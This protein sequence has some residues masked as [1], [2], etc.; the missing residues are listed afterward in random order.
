MVSAPKKLSAGH[1]R[2]LG[3]TPEGHGTNFAI[4]GR[5][6][7]SME[8][9]L[10]H[11]EKD[12]QPD[13]ITLSEE[14]YRSG[15]YWHVHVA[16]VTAGQLYAWRVKETFSNAPGTHFDPEKVLLDPYG[17][18]IVLSGNYDRQLSA[19]PGSNLH[20]CAKN[21]VV[22]LRHY[23]WE[24]DHYPRHP[25]SRSVIYEMHVGGF[26]KDPS[27]GLPDYLRG[28]YAG[29]ISKIPYLQ[30]L[31]IT[32]VELLPI[33]QF[34]PQDARPG[35]SNYWG[36]SP[37][38]FFA[39]HAE[40]ASVGSHLGVL[41]EFRD[42]VKALHKAN[43]EVILD[44]VYNHTAEGG[45][46]GPVI[47]FRGLDNDAFYTLDEHYRSTNYSGC[48]NTLDASHPMTKKMI[49]DS[50]RF[51]REEM[52]VDGFR[53][54]LA[55]ILSRDSYGQPMS[56]PP[57]IRTI[58]NA[59]SLADAKL[60][61]EAWDAGGLYL[62]GKMVGDRWREWNGRF[63]DDVR[64]FIKG[65]DGMVSAFATRL[66]GS[67]DIY[68]PQYTDPYKSLNFITCHDGF[69]LWD[70]VSY[71]QKHN[72]ENGENNRDGNNDNYSWNHGVEGPT[73]DPQINALRLR[74][75]KNFFIINLL[76]GGTPMIQM[77]D[78]T[79][80]TQ[81]GN[82]NV[83]CQDNPTSWLNWQPGLHGREMLRFV[84]ELM[85]YRSILKEEPRAFF[86]LAKALE[87]AKIDWHGVQPFQP[88]WSDASHALGLT[89]YDPGNRADVYAFFNAW[90]KPLT[91]TLPTPPHYPQGRWKR[92][93]DT[94]LLP[95]ADITPLGCDYTE[96]LT[97]EYQTEPRSV[98]VLV[99]V[100]NS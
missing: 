89:A 79:L 63:R 84:T 13:I 95:P 85:R 58:D 75:V 57:T 32:A 12:E 69:T 24:D 82:N 35:K 17:Q 96:V 36:Y 31:G 60:F 6:A 73:D 16:G 47:C 15:Y 77:G 29:V 88:D 81:S 8:L 56:D 78:E 72:E 11:S 80:R 1:C 92:V 22:D 3:A 50:L 7:K 99:C 52:H 100:H 44:V 38:G 53:F 40:Y 4:W 65:D 39:P 19:N 2:Q 62:V 74:Q 55:A 37:M 51:W 25:L 23:D 18:R 28:T 97:A 5:L 54:D 9:L 59:Y 49:T 27:S 41:T 86:S 21:A 61:A 14:Q 20:C 34:D 48:G 42:M 98:V 68:R 33:F 66:I 67:P 26:T 90:W 70:L 43:I 30:E 76:S 46:D 71:N 83:Y 94:G 64:R 45:D 93:C 10:F 91:V 87:Y